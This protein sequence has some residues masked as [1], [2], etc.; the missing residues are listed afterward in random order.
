MEAILGYGEDGGVPMPG[1]ESQI[2]RSAKRSLIAQRVGL[3]GIQAKTSGR[4]WWGAGVGSPLMKILFLIWEA[5]LPIF[6]E[7]DSHLAKV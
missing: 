4:F 6:G 7:P 1:I 2:D 5:M 3:L